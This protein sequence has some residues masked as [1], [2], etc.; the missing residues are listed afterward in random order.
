MTNQY[1]TPHTGS[2]TAE[3]YSSEHFDSIFD[4]Y[5][6][7]DA[8]PEDDEE[9]QN[10]ERE[11]DSPVHEVQAW[12]TRGKTGLYGGGG[13]GANHIETGWMEDYEEEREGSRILSNMGAEEDL[14]GME[15]VAP[16]RF[17]SRAAREQGLE[18]E[19][20]EIDDTST[21]LAAVHQ[22]QG[23]HHQRKSSSGTDTSSTNEPVTP[24]ERHLIS[25]AYKY[26]AISETKGRHT[27]F[28]LDPARNSTGGITPLA[29]GRRRSSRNPPPAIPD[30]L[31][32][33]PLKADTS[34]IVPP[35]Q[36]SL[37]PPLLINDGKTFRFRT[38]SY[39]DLKGVNT[40]L[41]LESPPTNSPPKRPSPFKRWNSQKSKSFV[42][43]NP[44]LPVGFVDSLGMTTFDLKPM[45]PKTKEQRIAEQD[46]FIRNL[47][48]APVASAPFSALLKLSESPSAVPL[49]AVAPAELENFTRMEAL[50]SR[51][52]DGFDDALT[53]AFRRLSQ[54]SNFESPSP[55]GR[56]TPPFSRQTSSHSARGSNSEKSS[57]EIEGS[58][59]PSTPPVVSPL[60]FYS[61]P[62]K[63][64]PLQSPA[65]QDQFRNPWAPPSSS[66]NPPRPDPSSPSSLS[67]CPPRSQMPSIKSHLNQVPELDALNS[68]SREAPFVS[69]DPEAH[70]KH[71][72]RSQSAI[73]AAVALG[74]SAPVKSLAEKQAELNERVRVAN[75]NAL[76]MRGNSLS[77]GSSKGDS[78]EGRMSPLGKARSL[79]GRGPSHQY[80]HPA[81]KDNTRAEVSATARKG[82]NPGW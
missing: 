31:L 55:D 51:Q 10:V 8:D 26:S 28:S 61:S 66:P 64:R 71:H 57:S 68:I 40:A 15:G 38:K 58:F 13:R 82:W 11:E 56:S 16:L 23:L 72:Y 36:T 76:L 1:Q 43:S 47:K 69:K 17:I 6:D 35:L 7:M 5:A 52:E 33:E 80:S 2:P 22:S 81:S 60:R 30:N 54:A 34:S 41:H 74:E 75:A 77:Y 21:S 29:G 18:D 63:V 12:D 53:E 62:I 73:V 39:T 42:I 20:R 46:A 79:L 27:S 32:A 59:I 78:R 49:P 44:I 50:R 14:E 24:L 3:S 70:Y 67:N 4:S 25:S 9:I 37:L 48:G 65:S 45:S 19:N